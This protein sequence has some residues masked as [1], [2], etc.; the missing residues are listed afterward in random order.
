MQ[1]P[2]CTTKCA[3]RGFLGALLWVCSAR[4]GVLT[5][6]FV[7]QCVERECVYAWCGVVS[8]CPGGL[9]VVRAGVAQLVEH[10]ICNQR[11]G[12]SNPFASSTYSN[13][14][15][16]RET[17][18]LKRMEFTGGGCLFKR[19]GPVLRGDPTEVHAPKCR[20]VLRAGPDA[21][22]RVAGGERQADLAGSPEADFRSW[23]ALAGSPA[24][25]L[26]RRG[27]LRTG[28]RAVNGSRL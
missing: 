8:D 18:S 9:F 28:G 4:E 27:A 1:P 3:L 19:P 16:D 2:D 13:R 14:S 20:R 26:C 25:G 6:I 21:L 15:K 22:K 24:T 10:L 5:L 17:A 7:P 11:V 12:G 23:G